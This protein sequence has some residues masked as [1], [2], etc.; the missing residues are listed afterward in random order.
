MVH[1]LG[2]DDLKNQTS[3]FMEIIENGNGSNLMCLPFIF[4]VNRV[5]Y[6]HIDIH[7]YTPTLIRTCH[8]SPLTYD[9]CEVMLLIS[10]YEL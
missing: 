4:F 1:I 10:A 2:T 7:A 3:L 5:S 6:C 9:A 8:F